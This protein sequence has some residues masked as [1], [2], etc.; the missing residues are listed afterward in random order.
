MKRGK[1][2]T[3]LLIIIVLCLCGCNANEKY[4]KNI[5]AEAFR[6]QNEEY[7]KYK[8]DIEE[9]ANE[10][11]NDEE[12]KANTVIAEDKYNFVNPPDEIPGVYLSEL[13]INNLLVFKSHIKAIKETHQVEFIPLNEP[14][15]ND[16][17]EL[18]HVNTD[19]ILHY[20]HE[21][22]EA[23]FSGIGEIINNDDNGLIIKESDIVYNKPQGNFLIYNN[24]TLTNKYGFVYIKI[25]NESINEYLINGNYYGDIFSLIYSYITNL[26]FY[27]NKYKSTTGYLY[28]LENGN[29]F[30]NDNEYILQTSL[31]WRSHNYEVLINT[32]ENSEHQYYFMD[33]DGNKIRI[34]EPVIEENYDIF[35]GIPDKNCFFIDELEKY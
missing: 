1:I 8:K 32:N 9:L 13:Y 10:L 25:S 16:H 7:L 30:Y 6:K 24:E 19:G 21:F 18:I 26:M 27:D 20:G 15:F 5:Y 22:T 23:S 2:M 3:K 4:K 17:I 28:R 35:Y 12:L 33:I 14:G 11:K 34:Y 29:I 31:Y